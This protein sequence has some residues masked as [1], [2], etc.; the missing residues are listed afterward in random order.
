[1]AKLKVIGGGPLPDDAGMPANLGPHGTRL[2][3]AVTDQVVVADIGGQVL[4]ELA[5]R[6][7]D[8]AEDCA[9]R[10]AEEGPTIMTKGGPREH[11]LLRCEIQNRALLSRLITKLGLDLEPLH[12][13]I[14]RPPTIGRV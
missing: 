5:A 4:L 11:P 8:R 9:G 10:I 2:W 6:A 13:T 7:F 1:M 3:R 12:R 14:G